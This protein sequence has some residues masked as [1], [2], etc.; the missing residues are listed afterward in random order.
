[1]GKVIFYLN[2]LFFC[3]S[4][5]MWTHNVN[6]NAN[7][8]DYEPLNLE[9]ITKIA[10][11]FSKYSNNPKGGRD[12]EIDDKLERLCGDKNI[13]RQ[14][15]EN[16]DD[17]IIDIDEMDYDRLEKELLKTESLSDAQQEVDF[18]REII[19]DAKKT[20]QKVSKFNQHY[21]YGIGVFKTK[22]DKNV[23]VISFRG[24][25]DIDSL[26]VTDLLQ[27]STI[28]FLD[29]KKRYGIYKSTSRI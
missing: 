15:F 27:S 7:D 6:A 13:G 4:C 20:L 17:I 11:D 14:A 18:L 2:M 3:G 24:T 25:K 26:A 29:Y 8:S 22:D 10:V 12:K 1:M 9:N 21:G 16:D 28:D 5:F 23:Y 19:G